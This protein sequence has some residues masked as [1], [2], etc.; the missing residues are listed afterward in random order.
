M[1][2]TYWLSFADADRPKGQQFLGVVIVDVSEQEAAAALAAKPDMHDQV[3]GPWIGA[4]IRACWQA[5]VNPGGEVGSMRIDDSA[6]P[7]ALDR[8]PRLTLLSRADVARL[9][10][11]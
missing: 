5:G 8:Y 3:E 7:G 10:P 2:R 4:A 11:Q 1:M 9:E 6:P